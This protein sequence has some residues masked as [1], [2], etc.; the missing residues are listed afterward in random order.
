[1]CKPLIHQG[2]TRSKQ[3]IRQGSDKH[4]D[5]RG[6]VM[7]RGLWYF[8]VDAILDVKLWDANV[9]TYTYNPMTAL[10]AGWENIKKYKHGRHNNDHQKF[11]VAVCSFSGR[12]AKEGIPSCYLSTDSIH[13]REKGRTPFTHTG[14]GKQ[15]H[16]YMQ[17]TNH[18]WS[19]NHGSPVPCGNRNRNGI[20]NQGLDYYVKLH[21]RVTPR[22]M[23][24]TPS[25]HA[26]TPPAHHAQYHEKNHR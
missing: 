17:G 24:Q 13:S 5:T 8:Q 7:I 25:S 23:L 18:G 11:L 26:V 2:H 15:T 16:Q 19:A 6:D 9:D 14:V 3:E 20:R 4:K 22:K 1:M 21:V 12:N 10:L